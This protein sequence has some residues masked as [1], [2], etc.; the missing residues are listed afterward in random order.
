MEYLP[1]SNQVQEGDLDASPITRRGQ[2]RRHHRR[3]RH[4][5]RLPRHRAPAGRRVGHPAR[6]HAAAAGARGPQPA[7]ADVPDCLPTSH[8]RTRRAASGCTRST[9]TR[10]RR[11]RRRQRPRPAAGRGRAAAGR[12]EPIPGTEREIPAELVLLAM[13]FVGPEKGGLLEDARR[14]ARRRAAT[15]RAT[16]SDMS[17]VDGVFVAGDMGRGQSLIVWAIAEGRAAAS[18]W[19]GSS[20]AT[21]PCRTRSCRPRGRSSDVHDL[22]PAARP[23]SD[24]LLV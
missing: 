20:P 6:D 5:R 1:P 13:G 16:T 22:T 15:S 24:G 10:V 23:P 2:A 14:G 9:P 7:V 3:R 8:A 19:T 12:F 18:G 17:N 11:R 4:R 21:P